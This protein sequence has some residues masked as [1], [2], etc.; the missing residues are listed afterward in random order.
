MCVYIYNLHISKPFSIAIP[1]LFN[2]PVHKKQQP[3]MKARYDNVNF[4]SPRQ[5]RK[6]ACLRGNS[7][8][9][10]SGSPILESFSHILG[11]NFSSL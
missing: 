11:S 5:T 7:Q 10:D 9:S 8:L 2:G 6:W 3:K 4:L 1:V